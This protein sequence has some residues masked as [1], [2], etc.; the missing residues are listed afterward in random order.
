MHPADRAWLTLA[1]GVVAY[2][3]AADDGELMS[4]G[5]DRYMLRHPWTTRLV[6]ALVAAH[7][8]NA[9]PARLDIVHWLFVL[10]RRWRRP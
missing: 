8:C 7:V 2:N 1:T 6:A 9:M 4:E 5:V 10:S 3:L